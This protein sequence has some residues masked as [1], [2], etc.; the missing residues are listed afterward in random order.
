VPQQ[1]LEGDTAQARADRT[2]ADLK[3]G[4]RVVQRDD[5]GE[6]DSDEGDDHP[7]S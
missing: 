4:R 1:R 7:P 6:V 5:A 2:M 3:A